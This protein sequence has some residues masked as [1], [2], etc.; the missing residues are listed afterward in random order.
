MNL[1]HLVGTY[2]YWVVFG[3][4][5]L[6]G[7]S[8]LLLGGFAAFSGYLEL[9]TVVGVAT[10]GSFLG[11][12][13]WFLLGRWHGAKLLE[14]FPRFAAPAARA[15]GLLARYHKPVILAVRFLY[16]LRIV[17]PFAIG[18]SR[19]PTLRFQYLNL[20]GAVLWAASGAGAGYLFGD[21]IEALL[22]NLPHYRKL[23]F[24]IL[25]VA[26]AAFWWFSRRRA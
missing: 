7:E 8:V 13:L 18:M 19:I 10:A 2:G 15:E 9:S 25:V 17:L 5:L 20:I 14:R 26:G 4:T 24:A 21:A 16:G 12:Q 3:G 6:E 23:A 11:D 22:G 1:A